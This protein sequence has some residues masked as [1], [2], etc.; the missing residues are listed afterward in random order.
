MLGRKY[1]FRTYRQCFI[2]EEAVSWM[3]HGKIATDNEH[4]LRIGND[5]M[6]LGLF[7]HVKFEHA[8]RNKGYF[9]RSAT[10]T[11]PLFTLQMFVFFGSSHGPLQ[12]M[13]YTILTRCQ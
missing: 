1:H 10:T 7:H 3:I 4:A 2:G 12:G 8:F 5:M 11:C 13:P 9:Y 6:K